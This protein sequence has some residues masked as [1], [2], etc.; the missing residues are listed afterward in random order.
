MDK[1]EKL[2]SSDFM[3]D[4]NSEPNFM[5]IRQDSEFSNIKLLCASKSGYTNVFSA[6]KYGKRYVL[7]CL[8]R[9]FQYTPIYRQAFVK[10]F[11]IGLQMDHPNICR[12][13]SME[14]VDDLGNCI[15][16][17]YVDGETLDKVVDNGK[18][19]EQLAWRIV[20]QLLDVMGY[21]HSKQIVHRDIKPSNI[22]LT[23]K[24]KDLKL[25]DF[26]LSDSDVFCVLKIPA[27]TI[28][29]IAPEQLQVG[30]KSEPIADVYS[31]GKVLEYMADATGCM[32]LVKV[33]RQCAASNPSC[34]PA[35]VTQIRAMLTDKV[36]R[37]LA[38]NA[39]LVFL[40][41]VL[42]IFI[43]VMLYSRCVVNDNTNPVDSTFVGA[44]NKVV[45]S[46]YW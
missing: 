42:S 44:G 8:K 6:V 12:T 11:E 19:T 32:R 35:D 14:N 15:V 41:V 37:L 24:G 29:Y 1:K 27:G 17:E 23:H 38:V 22:M 16:M 26:G 33:G 9:E 20:R 21:M 45:D 18:L 25:I 46:N 34:R 39:V 31:F 10:E 36:H 43:G 28:G 40:A 7:K 2:S 30:A 4:F 5:S 13:V 3:A